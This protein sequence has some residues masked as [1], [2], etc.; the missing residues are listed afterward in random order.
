MRQDRGR[1]PRVVVDDL[2]LGEAGLGIED[3]VE[4]GELEL[5]SFDDDF[6]VSWSRG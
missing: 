4:V 3:L 5:A 1:D 2:A 6:D